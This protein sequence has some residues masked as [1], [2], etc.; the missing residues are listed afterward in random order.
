MADSK[1]FKMKSDDFSKN[2][3]F[4]G[5]VS[6]NGIQGVRFQQIWLNQKDHVGNLLCNKWSTYTMC[7]YSIKLEITN[8]PILSFR[9]CERLESV[10][11]VYCRS[12]QHLTTLYPVSVNLR[13]SQDDSDMKHRLPKHHFLGILIFIITER[14]VTTVENHQR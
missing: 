13:F 3:S 2:I 8:I 9:S 10:W 4:L 6:A 11:V 12:M 5:T 14:N 1:R 7:I